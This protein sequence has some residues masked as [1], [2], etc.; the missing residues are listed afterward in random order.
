MKSNSHF[1]AGAH[2]VP[3]NTKVEADLSLP[4][5]LL[6]CSENRKKEKIKPTNPSD[7]TFSI[8]VSFY[9]EE[10]YQTWNKS[11]LKLRQ[12]VS[13]NCLT[14]WEE[15]LFLKQ[16]PLKQTTEP[17]VPVGEFEL[18]KHKMRKIDRVSD[19]SSANRF[20]F[21]Y[22]GTWCSTTKHFFKFRL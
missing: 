10:C 13:D 5:L 2:F 1:F 22:K 14:I 12:A 17:A 11:V 4:N 15:N 7:T 20:D 3:A 19:F 21:L 18:L 16:F 8:M 6:S 9:S